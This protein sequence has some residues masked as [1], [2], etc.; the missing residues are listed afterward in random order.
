M[1]FLNKIKNDLMKAESDVNV[2]KVIK[3][4][5]NNLNNQDDWKFFVGK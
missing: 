1:V 2:N 3:T 4:I 5:D